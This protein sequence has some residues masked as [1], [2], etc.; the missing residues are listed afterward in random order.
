MAVSGG[1][2]AVTTVK[3]S[4]R[5]TGVGREGGVQEGWEGTVLDVIPPFRGSGVGEGT[6]GKDLRGHERLGSLFWILVKEG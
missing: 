6:P 3:V 1:G 5:S 4:I 2:A